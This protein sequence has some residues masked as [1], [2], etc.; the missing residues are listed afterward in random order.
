MDE[1]FLSR[2]KALI[3]NHEGR[4]A[5]VYLDTMGHPTIGIG[6]NLDRSD[7][8][9]KIA[10][11]GL[12]Y[13]LVRGGQQDLTGAQIDELFA[14]DVETAVAGARM[15]VASFDELASDAQAVLVDMVFNLGRVGLSNFHHMIAALADGD[16]ERA[17]EEMKNSTWAAQVPLRANQD[18]AMMAAASNAIDETQGTTT[19]VA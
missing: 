15:V 1:R 8:P 5:H 17:A 7:A 3:A 2:V 10:A 16:Y 6:F 11:L 13:D 12:S 14:A 9:H 18:I 19:T 4:R